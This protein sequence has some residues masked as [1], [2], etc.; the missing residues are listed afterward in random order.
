MG[1]A[2]PLRARARVESVSRADSANCPLPRPIRSPKSVPDTV[3]PSR[4]AECHDTYPALVYLT[5]K[6]RVAATATLI[7]AVP[8]MLAALKA[9]IAIAICRETE[10]RHYTF[11]SHHANRCGRDREWGHDHAGRG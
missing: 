7:A 6:V 5:D 3:F 10:G 9:W 8:D 2:S 11:D 4:R 1:R